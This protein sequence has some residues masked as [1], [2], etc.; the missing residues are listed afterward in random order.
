M[1]FLARVVIFWVIVI[2]AISL[3]RL[4]PHSLPARLLFSEH[5]PQPR[6][7][8]PCSR[9]MLRRAAYWAGWVLQCAFVSGA[10][11]VLAR[12]VPMLA[13]ALWFTVLW[14]VVVPALGTIAS[15][16][17]LAAL[18]VWGKAKVIGP[19]PP[20]EYTLLAGQVGTSLER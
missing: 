12:Q 10:G 13:D 7:G 15:L 16:A 9:Y 8:E 1:P 14:L 17:G 19:D 4:Y 6:R 3:L 2:A 20:H 11:F 5:G 18:A